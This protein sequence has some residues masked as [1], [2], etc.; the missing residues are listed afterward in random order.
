[1]EYAVYIM[2]LAFDTLNLWTLV[3]GEQHYM[4]YN[5]IVC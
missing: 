1:M 2:L 5:G 3:S 4:Y